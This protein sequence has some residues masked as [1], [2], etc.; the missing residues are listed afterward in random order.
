[1]SRDLPKPQETIFVGFDPGVS[2]AMVCLGDRGQYFAARPLPIA[3][4]PKHRFLDAPAFGKMLDSLPRALYPQAFVEEL[5]VM[6]KRTGIS[7]MSSGILY[8]AMVGILQLRNF[9]I[10]NVRPQTWQKM[11]LSII[12]ELIVL[13]VIV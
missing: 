1:M 8:G 2:G 11:T 6:P 12:K 5:F 10:T 3:G 7:A 13:A 9:A 4:P